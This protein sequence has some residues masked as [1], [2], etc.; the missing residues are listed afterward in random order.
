MGI[1]VWVVLGLVVGIIAKLIMPGKDPG[2]FIIT[3][4]LGI[5]GAFVGGFI[6]T[7]LG[8]GSVTGFDIRSLLIAV[9]GAIILLG[10]YRFVKK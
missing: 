8:L 10:I 3:I 7:R 5:A 2:G 6:A 9:G 1:L 4:I